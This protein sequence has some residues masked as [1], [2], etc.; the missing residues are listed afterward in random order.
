MRL[1][2][3]QTSVSQVLLGGSP[4]STLL[5]SLVGSTGERE[6]R[7]AVYRNSV[8]HTLLSVLE[9]AFPVLRQLIGEEC[10]TAIGL[11]F[12]AQHPPQRP[13]LYA[14]GDGFSEFLAA[15]QPMANLPWLADIARLEWARNEALFA[16]EGE[17]LTPKQLATVPSDQLPD[18]PVSL[19]PSVRLLESKWPIHAIWEA[20]QPDGG[21]LEAVDL[22]QAQ[23]VMVWRWEGAVVQQPLSTAEFTLLAAFAA[24]RPLAEAADMAIESDVTFDLATALACFLKQGVLAPCSRQTASDVGYVGFSPRWR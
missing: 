24:H 8:R 4:N 3:L 2:E 13:V 17:L 11:T 5:A 18:L 22:K 9:A 1:V 20:H 21:P 14:Y 19:H 23:F 7:L 15:F 10:F 6:R 16:P 12:I